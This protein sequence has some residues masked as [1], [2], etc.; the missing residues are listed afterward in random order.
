M[1]TSAN[2]RSAYYDS[3]SDSN[4]S[5]EENTDKRD[6][7]N[8]VLEDMTSRTSEESARH[9][10]RDPTHSPETSYRLSPQAIGSLFRRPNQPSILS[11]SPTN[12]LSP[13]LHSYPQ[14]HTTVRVSQRDDPPHP[15]PTPITV[16]SN[17]PSVVTTTTNQPII[18]HSP[19]V[20]PSSHPRCIPPSSHPLR[21]P[22]SN[23][24]HPPTIPYVYHP[25]TTP[26]VYHPQASWAWGGPVYQW[27]WTRPYLCPKP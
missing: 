20:P 14:P 9:P 24:P 18:N 26:H 10:A 13:Q 25:P 1:A 2:V 7:V 6:L 21:I 16:P 22:P 5:G 12:I 17:N 27:R 4:T 3:S 8:F 11:L 23:H 15:I 19:H